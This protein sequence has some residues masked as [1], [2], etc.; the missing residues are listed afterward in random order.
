MTPHHRALGVD[1]VWFRLVPG[2]MAEEI[3]KFVLDHGPIGC[4][5]T[6]TNRLIGHRRPISASTPNRLQVF[7]S[8][9]S[10]P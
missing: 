8:L 6:L 3:K 4:F 5:F 10:I 7:L 9:F 1:Q 2:S